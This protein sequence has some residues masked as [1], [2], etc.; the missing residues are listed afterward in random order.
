VI[1]ITLHVRHGVNIT[2]NSNLKELLSVVR[3][4][5]D[6]LF[7]V[8][9][10]ALLVEEGSYVDNNNKLISRYEVRNIFLSS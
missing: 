2:Y 5:S 7:I 9:L 6:T 4:N 8:G 1:Y 10:N 3:D